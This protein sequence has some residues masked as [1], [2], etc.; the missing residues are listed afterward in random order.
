MAWRR[1]A[2]VSYQHRHGWHQRRINKYVATMAA[3]QW[4][5]K[6]R[7]ACSGVAVARKRGAGNQHQRSW[8]RRGGE[9]LMAKMAK[10]RKK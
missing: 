4:R 9:K 2:Y 7:M 10:K 6:R 3:Y 1:G 8:R 5:N